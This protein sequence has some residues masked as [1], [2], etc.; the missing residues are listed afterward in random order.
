MNEARHEK[1]LDFSFWPSHHD[2]VECKMAPLGSDNFWVTN[3]RAVFVCLPKTFLFNNSILLYEI[4]KFFFLERNY[5]CLFLHLVGFIN[6][7]YNEQNSKVKSFDYR[8][9]DRRNTARHFNGSRRWWCR[10]AIFCCIEIIDSSWKW[11]PS[12][13]SSLAI[14]RRPRNP[15]SSCYLSYFK[16]LWRLGAFCIDD[17]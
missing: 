13:K 1:W 5:I 8:L 11:G 9:A 6:V 15:S 16:F 12:L 14:T 2:F 7:K 17:Y 3:W 10:P 4:V